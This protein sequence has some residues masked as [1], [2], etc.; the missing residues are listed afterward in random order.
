MTE[1]NCGSDG[2]LAFL[3]SMVLD[4]MRFF[5]VFGDLGAAGCAVWG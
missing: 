3:R 1:E 2:C 5:S 4:G